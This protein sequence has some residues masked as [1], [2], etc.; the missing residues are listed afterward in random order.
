MESTEQ[1]N[2]EIE[3]SNRDMKLLEEKEQDMA[4]ELDR[5]NNPQEIVKS[6]TPEVKPN[7]NADT[8]PNNSPYCSDNEEIVIEDDILPDS[9]EGANIE[10]EYIK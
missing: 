7:W 3:I 6:E 4:T 5:G 8:P 1:L 10:K 2:H 9:S